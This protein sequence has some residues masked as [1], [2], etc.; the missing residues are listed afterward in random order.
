[1]KLPAGQAC[2]AGMR[3]WLGLLTLP[4][5]LGCNGEP[6]AAGRANPE[7]ADA[8]DSDVREPTAEA[9]LIRVDGVDDLRSRFNHDAEKLR[10]VAL[11][12]PG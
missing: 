6:E 5:F 3:R 4:L 9:P 7:P 11:L 2:R 10:V 12:E 8:K 1:M